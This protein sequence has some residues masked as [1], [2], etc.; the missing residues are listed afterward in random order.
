[1]RYER[2]EQVCQSINIPPDSLDSFEQIFLINFNVCTGESLCGDSLIGY[3]NSC[4]RNNPSILIITSDTSNT[5]WG[6]KPLHPSIK[7]AI[8]PHTIL[9]KNGLASIYPLY[10][11]KHKKLKRLR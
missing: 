11:H 7:I 9:Q 10:V 8:V 3:I 1:M 4:Y 2:L 6:R 5:I